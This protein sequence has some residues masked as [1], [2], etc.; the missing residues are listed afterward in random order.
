MS[1]KTE[2]I[3][4]CIWGIAIFIFLS[5]YNSDKVKTF[6]SQTLSVLNNTEEAKILKQG[7]GNEHLSSSEFSAIFANGNGLIVGHP[8]TVMAGVVKNEVFNRAVKE[9]VIRFTSEPKDVKLKNNISH[10]TE[11]DR[12]IIIKELLSDSQSHNCY[13]FAVDDYTLQRVNIAFTFTSKES[14]KYKSWEF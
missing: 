5:Y 13:I 4:L 2:T 8:T 12:V 11:E 10:L 9:N 7:I 3:L 1:K 14:K 6:D